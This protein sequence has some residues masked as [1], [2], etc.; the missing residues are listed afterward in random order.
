[1]PESAEQI[2]SRINQWLGDEYS[3]PRRYFMAAEG[4]FYNRVPRRFR[5]LPLLYWFGQ[6]SWAAAAP[7]V[8]YV[9][10]AVPLQIAAISAPV[11]FVGS[12]ALWSLKALSERKGSD[13]TQSDAIVRFGDLISAVKSGAVP[14]GKRAEAIRAC[15][16]ILEI[17][18]RQITKVGKGEIS[19]SLV[20]YVGSSQTK[21]TIRHRN[22]GNER[23]IGR[24]FDGSN[25]LGH[26]ACMAG[27]EPRVVHKL[28]AID[29]G[30]PSPTQSKVSYSSLFFIPIE[31]STSEGPRVRAFVSLDC[32]R[33]YAFY[34]NRSREVVVTCRPFVDQIKELLRENG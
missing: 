17:H 19:V 13:L 10:G 26:H 31:V 34:G 24:E 29:R 9:A 12:A 21:M 25:L 18:A 30:T 5:L 11:L 22:P 14:R 1:M 3:K 20:E 7:V 28:S 23:P 32:N 15:L 33:P 27:V 8:G 4:V 16:G 2:Q 6:H